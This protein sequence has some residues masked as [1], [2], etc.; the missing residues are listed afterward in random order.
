VVVRMEM[1]NLHQGKHKRATAQM[2]GSRTHLR[3]E[4]SENKP[5]MLNCT[6]LQYIYK[7]LLDEKVNVQSFQ[8]YLDK[9]RLYF[10][11]YND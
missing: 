1:A 7:L 10:I 5:S 3:V 6:D 11:K 9:Q 8:G 4:Q 2:H